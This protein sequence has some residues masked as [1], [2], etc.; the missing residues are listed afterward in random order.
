[1]VFHPCIPGSSPPVICMIYF[2]FVEGFI[3]LLSFIICTGTKTNLYHVM[4]FMNIIATLTLLWLMVDLFMALF[5]ILSWVM[6]L[7]FDC[8]KNEYGHWWLYTRSNRIGIFID[9]S[10]VRKMNMGTDDYIHGQIEFMSLLTPHK[11]V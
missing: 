1:M 9:S 11:L 8:K 4:L 7:S 6:L 5:P 2:F 3:I 10:S